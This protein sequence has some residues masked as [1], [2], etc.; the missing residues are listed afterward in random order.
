MYLVAIKTKEGE[1]ELAALSSGTVVIIIGQ[2]VV[3]AYASQSSWTVETTQGLVKGSIAPDGDYYTFLGLKYGESIIDKNR[4]MSQVEIHKQELIIESK[5]IQSLT[6]QLSIKDQQGRLNNLEILG[7]PSKKG[8]NLIG[9]LKNIATKVGF[10]LIPADIDYIHRVRRFGSNS[11]SHVDNQL[12]PNI[13]VR[14]TQRKRKNDMLA[15]A[16]VRRGLTSADA[17]VDGPPTSIFINDHLTPQNK[18]LYRRTRELGKEKG[19]K[20]IW[21]NNCQIFVRKSD[22]CK[23]VLIQNDSD[24]SKI[25]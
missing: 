7:I 12:P 9:I 17:G 18:I 5:T 15:A 19:Y 23:A 13:I 25:K 6:E 21:I 22:T 1:E 10:D 11:K 16:R 14:F 4:F 20:Y 8:E 2:S 24:L 3:L